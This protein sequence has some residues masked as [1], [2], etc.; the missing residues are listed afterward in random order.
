M[1]DLNGLL[2]MGEPEFIYNFSA[3]DEDESEY[4][5]VPTRLLVP[6]CL[7]PE[8]RPC[9]TAFVQAG[10]ED[11]LMRSAVWGGVVPT[12]SVPQIKTIIGALGL[13][14]LKSGAG[15]TGLPVKKDFARQIVDHL[16][17]AATD[18]DLA[19]MLGNL[20]SNKP[21]EEKWQG[22]EEAIMHMVS[23]LDTENAEE[24]KPMAS[25]AKRRL[26]EKMQ[27]MGKEMAETELQKK[28]KEIINTATSKL[29]DK[30]KMC[31]LFTPQSYQSCL[32]L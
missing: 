27:A 15:K 19:R 17:P 7:P 3:R 31:S 22:E 20:L 23:C 6:S 26:H 9:G 14:R 16:F 32:I 1:L 13:P 4:V 5:H 12:L 10:A 24:F 25:L 21:T 18:G 11:S 8:I 29:Q 2:A 28:T 30:S